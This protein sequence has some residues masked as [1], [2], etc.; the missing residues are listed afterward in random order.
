[1]RN[2][3]KSL[4]PK[5]GEI[6]LI[7]RCPTL[8]ELPA[9]PRDK[10]GWPWTEESLQLPDA[11]PDSSPWPKVSIVTPSF[12]QA[13]F[14]EETIRSVLLQ[15]Y[16]NLEYIVVDGGSS[17]GSIEIIRKYEPWLTYWVS[18]PDKGQADAINKGFDRCTGEILA[19]LNSDDIYTPNAVACVVRY[20]AEHSQCNI[21]YGEAWYIDENGYRLR[22]IRYVTEMIQ[23][24]CILNGNIVA[25]PAAFWRRHLWLTIG[26]LD[27][28]LTWGLDW[29]FFIRAYFHTELNY[30]P[31]FL[32]S[33]RLHKNMKSLMTV[34]AR[35]AEIARI[36]RQYGGWWQPTNIA[37]QVT[38]PWHLFNRT[39]P[40]W[41]S[42]IKKPIRL[43]LLA[44]LIV[45]SR[46]FPGTFTFMS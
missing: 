9:P 4:V 1:M 29:E 37:Y 12:N 17:D 30:V 38:R 5:A 41:P 2:A 3:E 18:E 33:C 11:M 8:S 24:R 39:T 26:K 27:T 10:T 32:A 6:E 40:K 20:F 22:P 28:H 13:R 31:E 44:P 19:W 7:M 23:K 25:Q 14:I 35:H 42:S 21:I 43:A 36:S 46:L 15:G 45:L 34:E 16:P